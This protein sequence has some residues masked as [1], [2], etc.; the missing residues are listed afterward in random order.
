MNDPFSFSVSS[1]LLWFHSP[2]IYGEKKNMTF[3][4]F[5]FAAYSLIECPVVQECY[6]LSIISRSSIIPQT[7]TVSCNVLL[8]INSNLSNLCSILMAFLSLCSYPSAVYKLLHFYHT[9]LEI[10][11]QVPHKGFWRNLCCVL[12]DRYPKGIYIVLCLILPFSCLWG[13]FR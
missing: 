13:V 2:I 4:T 8:V 10:T 12:T 1:W 11:W 6:S 9:L 5:E 3:D 7:S